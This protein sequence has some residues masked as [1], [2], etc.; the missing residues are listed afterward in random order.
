MSMKHLAA[1]AAAL[2]ILGGCAQSNTVGYTAPERGDA[3]YLKGKNTR[4]DEVYINSSASP[5][6]RDFRDIYIAPA[7]LSKLQII[8]PEGVAADEEWQV[9]DVEEGVLQTAIE[10]EFSAALAYQSAFNIVASKDQAELVV[11]TTV[12]AIHPNANLE[13]VAAGAKSGGAITVSIALVNAKSDVVLVRS[14]DT[15]STDD[16]WAF[17]Q[18]ENDDDAVN[19]I[20]RSWGN[21]M[22]RGILHLQGRSNDPLAAPILTKEQK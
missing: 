4:A 18:V 7:N 21:S 6:G 19:L 20:F 22:R 5:G 3:D 13:Q 11:Y 8:Q 10:D 2:L 15:K 1:M 12:V 17:H 16:I 9:N 14:V